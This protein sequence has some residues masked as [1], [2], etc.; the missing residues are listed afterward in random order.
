VKPIFY[1]FTLPVVGEI[2]FPAYMTMLLLGFVVCLWLLR[3]EEDRAGRDGNE[4]VDLGILMLACG[5]FG[6]RIL[7]VLADGH[8]QDFVNLCVDPK[9]VPALDAKVLFCT[10]DAQC[11]YDYLC[12]LETSKCYPPKDCLAALK[13]WEGG[14][15]YYGGFLFAAPV[16]IIYA[17][18]KGLGAWRVADLASPFIALGLVF[19]RTGCFFNGCCYGKPS[20]LPWAVHFPG[21]AGHVHPTQVYEALGALGIAAFLY[22][23]I[24]P[25][26]ARDGQ[27]FAALLVLY[28]ALRFGLEFLRADERGELHGLSTSQWIGLPLAALGLVLWLVRR[29]PDAAARPSLGPQ[30][31][32]T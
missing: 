8:L 32:E 20:H 4:I 21:V 14:L 16:G 24:R 23:V 22:W 2:V 12:N 18:R 17:H 1:K 7:S 19:G 9:K 27:V 11:G 13:V 5:V 31:K 26:K 28:A 10:T 3:R 29:R 30:G 15:A 6:A 25:R